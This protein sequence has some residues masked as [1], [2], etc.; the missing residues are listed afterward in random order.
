MH[1]F[2]SFRLSCQALFSTREVLA[3]KLLQTR[4]QAF[5]LHR[6]IKHNR[7]TMTSLTRRAHK[8]PG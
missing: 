7:L 8:G 4:V 2:G 3:R 5:L 1:Q 6:P